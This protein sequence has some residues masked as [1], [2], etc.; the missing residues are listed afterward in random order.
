M[1]LTLVLIPIP[2]DKVEKWVAR[3][4]CGISSK[5][6]ESPEAVALLAVLAIATVSQ[7]IN[8]GYRQNDSPCHFKFE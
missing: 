8:R 2:R 7:P 5:W 1:T 3:K 6:L 4:G